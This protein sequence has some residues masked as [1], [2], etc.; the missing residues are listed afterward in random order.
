MQTRFGTLEI[1]GP[2]DGSQDSR[3]FL[4]SKGERAQLLGGSR[5]SFHQRIDWG[6]K[7]EVV[8]FRL[9]SGGAH[10]CDSYQIVRLTG[11][12]AVVSKEFGEHGHDF[13]GFHITDEVISFR[14]VR[15]FPANIDYQRVDYD[16]LSATVTNVMK[17]DTGVLPAG[18]GDEV[19]RWIGASA[20]QIFE[21]PAE[22]VRFRQI[23]SD[24]DLKRFRTVIANFG[25]YEIREGMLLATGCWPSQCHDKYGFVGIEVATGIPF[26]VEFHEGKRRDF[27]PEGARL[28][29]P[30]RALI[31]EEKARREKSKGG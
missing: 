7:G 28:P 4:T 27:L 1:L 31:E 15:D 5:F 29:A 20:S 26:A 23:M 14:M 8:I 30:L 10:C 18:A 9:W 25:H 6:K 16:G 22:R 3:V 13:H 19:T 2:G 11:D 24:A 17:N 21:D 12:G